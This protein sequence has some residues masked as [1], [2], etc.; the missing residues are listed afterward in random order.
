MLFQMYKMHLYFTCIV[1]SE[2]TA[3]QAIMTSLKAA[4]TFKFEA[5]RIR[6]VT[7]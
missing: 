1:V 5:K 2:A 7:L 6:S 4:T 3:I